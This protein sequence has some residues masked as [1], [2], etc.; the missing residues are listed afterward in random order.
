[1]AEPDHYPVI[2]G[3]FD[4]VRRARA[5]AILEP[6][7][8]ERR[9][10][11]PIQ[12]I[13][14]YFAERDRQSLNEILDAVFMPED[15]PLYAENIVPKYTA[16]FSILLYIN[17]GRYIKDFTTCGALSDAALPFDPADPPSRF[18][19]SAKDP[20]FFSRFCEEQ[21][22]FCAPTFQRNML[23][24][25]FESERILPITYK[26]TLG[27]GGSGTVYKIKIHKLYNELITDESKAVRPCLHVKFGHLCANGSQKFRNS[28]KNR[29]V[30]SSSKRTSPKRP[31]NT[32]TMKSPH[33]V[34]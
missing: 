21:W 17:K 11:V 22:R 27:G 15:P 13:Q 1:M 32:M 31:E 6:T 30:P 24:D 20:N 9:A 25:K 3:F 7:G 8:Q 28:A 12:K 18:P 16:V 5:Y 34:G 33:F 14:T 23:D 4:W 10:F 2:Q 29:R 19:I 26:K